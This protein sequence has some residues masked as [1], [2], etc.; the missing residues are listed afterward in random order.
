MVAGLV[1]ILLAQISR[2]ADAKRGL[3]MQEVF[4]GKCL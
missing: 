3:D 1:S 4:W 2:E